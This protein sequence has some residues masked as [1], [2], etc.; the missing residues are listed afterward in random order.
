MSTIYR[1]DVSYDEFYVDRI[2]YKTQ[3]GEERYEL[4]I[5]LEYIDNI[6]DNLILMNSILDEYVKNREQYIL[7]EYNRKCK[8]PPFKIESNNINGISFS[9]F[10]LT[11]FKRFYVDNIQNIIDMSNAYIGVIDELDDGWTYVCDKKKLKKDKINKLLDE[12][13]QI[14]HTQ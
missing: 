2:K 11:Q 10:T 3:K 5:K 12:L 1:S 14:K 13:H 9:R 8:Y 4:I 7:Y 6:I